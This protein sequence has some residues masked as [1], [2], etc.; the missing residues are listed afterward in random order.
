MSAGIAGESAIRNARTT[1]ETL[2]DSAL[3][4]QAEGGAWRMIGRRYDGTGD[5]EFQ[6]TNP[7]AAPRIKRWAGGKVYDGSRV[8]AKS[9]PFDKYDSSLELKREKVV[10]D[11]L[12]TTAELLRR[13]ANKQRRFI[14]ELFFAKLNTNP[15][16]L[17]GKALIAND[18]PFGPAG[19]AWDNSHSTPLSFA[20]YKTAR[21]R[22]GARR[23]EAGS[24]LGLKADV[25]VVGTDQEQMALEIAEA[26]DRPVAV[27]TNS[28]MDGTASAA[29][30]I[31][32]VWRGKIAV[33]IVAPELD[34]GKWLVGDSRFPHLLAA[35]IWRDP[36]V[37]ISDAM[38]AEHR[39]DEDTFKY[40][41]EG[42]MNFG[43][44]E[45][46]A[47]EGKLS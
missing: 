3:A 8:L 27:G 23:D 17:D 9:V 29:T 42:D 30:S 31:T 25:I 38:N 16:G 7:G 39:M 20:A 12:G 4:A 40:S 2:A 43:G 45:S 1:Y 32:N 34:S 26:S 18:H 46:I 13:H 6:I 28:A 35:V 10:H 22:L 14:D 11:R 15:T 24:H 21:A 41:V 44:L 37:V 47:W 36:E 19:A 33:V 5:I